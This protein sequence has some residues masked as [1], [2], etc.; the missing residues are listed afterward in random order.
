MHGSGADDAND[1]GR[2]TGTEKHA[3]LLLCHFFSESRQSKSLRSLP[4]LKV[5]DRLLRLFS[6]RSTNEIIGATSSRA[7]I[8][9][10]YNQTGASS[11]LVGHTDWVEVTGASS[12][13]VGHTD[14]VEVVCYTRKLEL[15]FDEPQVRLFSA[16]SDALV[17]IWEPASRLNAALY[18]TTG[19]FS[20]HEGAVLCVYVVVLV[21]VL[22]IIIMKKTVPSVTRRSPRHRRQHLVKK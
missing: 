2:A 4:D 16:G 7:L 20:G 13:L 8:I 18:H 15:D 14:W 11:V 3:S 10:R 5:P 6:V 17:R 9:W 19:K 1:D 12:V 21:L 22:L